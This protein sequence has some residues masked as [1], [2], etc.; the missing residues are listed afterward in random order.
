M[1]KINSYMGFAKRSGNLIAGAET[2][3]IYMKKKKVKL[4]LIAEDASENS[5]KKMIS[6]ANSFGVRY[7]VYGDSQELSKAVG[8]PGRTVFGI[9]SSDFADTIEK[10]I[11]KD[12]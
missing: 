2:C 3:I 12:S 8:S 5:K 4:L 9:L 11:Q 10:E 1:S 6:S 7:I